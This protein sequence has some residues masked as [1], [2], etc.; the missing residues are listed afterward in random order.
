MAGPSCLGTP[1]GTRFIP[2]RKRREMGLSMSNG[3]SGI[4]LKMQ[5]P[6]GQFSARGRA[7]RGLRNSLRLVRRVTRCTTAPWGPAGAK[8]SA[9]TI[10]LEN[11]FGG[12]GVESLRSRQHSFE[13]LVSYCVIEAQRR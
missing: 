11:W 13:R 1:D 3:N 12:V 2:A 7:V 8:V 10:N 9:T 4:G 5:R 6:K